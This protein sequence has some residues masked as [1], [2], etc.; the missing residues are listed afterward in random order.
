MYSS[1]ILLHRD[2]GSL[3]KTKSGCHIG[4]YRVQV[5]VN[6]LIHVI[7]GIGTGN[8]GNRKWGTLKD[9]GVIKIFRN[10]NDI[11]HIS[12]KKFF[13]HNRKVILDHGNL[14]NVAQIL[15]QT[16]RKS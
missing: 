5:T 11:F 14:M 2:T 10:L 1:G 13:L 16:I 6:L 15:D 7:R 12:V 3:R 8:S 9:A 4:F